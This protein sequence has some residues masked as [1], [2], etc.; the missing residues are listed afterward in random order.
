MKAPSKYFLNRKLRWMN[1]SVVKHRL[2]DLIYHARHTASLEISLALLLEAHSH[3]I[4]LNRDQYKVS[5]DL[6]SFIETRTSCRPISLNL[7][8][9]EA[10]CL[11][12]QN[13][14]NRL[15]QNISRWFY[16]DSRLLTNMSIYRSRSL[17][18][19]MYPLFAA[20]TQYYCLLV[21]R[22]ISLTVLMP[23]SCTLLYHSWRLSLYRV[24]SV[25]I[26][27]PRTLAC[28]IQQATVF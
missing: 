14:G 25:S 24:C 20:C 22:C 3:P 23:H 1:T 27:A 5:C 15:E 19:F 28:H 6:I 16:F 7:S 8:C 12:R 13:S 17:K 9:L 11:S 26:Y 18:A 4:R 10:S 2:Q 21:K